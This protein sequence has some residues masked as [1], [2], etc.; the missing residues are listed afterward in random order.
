MR[1]SDFKNLTA[2]VA[3][4]MF[5]MRRTIKNMLRAI[6]FENVIEAENGL[7]AW[8]I[9]NKSKIDIMVSD[10][11]MPEMPGLELLRRVRD[12]SRLRDLPFIMITAEVAEG[13]IVQAAETEV[14]GYLIK[15][16]VAK[17]LEEK[18][19][20]IFSNRENPS[21]FERNMKAGQVYMDS[22]QYDKAIGAFTESLNIRPDSAR[23]RF[24]LGEAHSK[25]GDMKEAEKWH[26][27]AMAVNPQYIRAYEG[28]SAVYDNLGKSDEAVK[29]LEKASQI[30]PN[31]PERY[32]EIGK[33]HLK[34]GDKEKADQ[35]LEMATRNAEHNPDIHTQIGEVYL[36]AGDDSKAA[37]AF[38][39]SIDIFESVHVYNR[40]G[41]ALRKKGQFD[42]ALK[43]YQRAIKLEPENEVLYFNV[44]RLLMEQAF[45]RDAAEY[46]RKALD[47]DP[48]FAECK[49]MLSKVNELSGKK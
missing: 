11:N 19:M 47:L 17:A 9:L 44:G 38:S 12:N 21:P 20:A 29:V 23:A 14:D 41:I 37:D 45:Y 40:L 33:L 42:E 4:D 35:A 18:I 30:S 1:Q 46:F 27:E 26:K 36:A 31:N 28:L 32:L 3:D 6:G 13:N 10:W 2:L 25:K 15:P 24:S 7:K 39:H 48:E 5:N 16:F 43:V 8:E 34:R 49:N 22:Q